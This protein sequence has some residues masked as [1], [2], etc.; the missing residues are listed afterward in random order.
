MN[1]FLKY[2]VLYFR[3]HVLQDNRVN[4]TT[5]MALQNMMLSE[6]SQTRKATGYVTPF[7]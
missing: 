3:K 5:W 6:R 1:I 7:I 4:P 2:T